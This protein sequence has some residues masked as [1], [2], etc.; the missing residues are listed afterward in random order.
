MAAQNGLM[1]ARLAARGFTSR[2]DALVVPRS[3][4]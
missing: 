4:E 3:R 2:A 1:A